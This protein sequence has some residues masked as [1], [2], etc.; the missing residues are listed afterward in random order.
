VLAARQ[1]PP[2]RACPDSRSRDFPSGA[3]YIKQLSFLLVILL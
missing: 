1:H 3:I 2:P